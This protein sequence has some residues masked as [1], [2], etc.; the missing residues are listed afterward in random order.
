MFTIYMLV[1]ESW[2]VYGSYDDR[3]RANEIAMQVR[4]ERGVEVWV[5]ELT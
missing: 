1:G 3:K 2:Y 4:D 5:R